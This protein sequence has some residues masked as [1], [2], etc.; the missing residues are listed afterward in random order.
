MH[1]VHAVTVMGLVLGSER[2]Q[3]KLLDY[4]GYSD[5]SG[6]VYWNCHG[7][8]LSTMQLVVFLGLDC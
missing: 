7:G 1:E 6:L 4:P 3:V 5:I 2:L 8:A